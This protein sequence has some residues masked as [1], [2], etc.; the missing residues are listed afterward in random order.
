MSLDDG[1][2]WHELRSNLPHAPVHWLEIQP[3]FNDLVV[4][5]YG[6]GFWIADDITPLQQLA[7]ADL[8]ADVTLVAPRP[9]YRFRFKEAPFQQPN[10]P[11]EG[12][13]PTYGASLHYW[14][15]ATSDEEN[16]DE[17]EGEQ[18]P[19]DPSTTDVDDT[20]S[21]DGTEPAPDKIEI[22]DTDG[23]LVRTLDEIPTGPGLH[24]VHWNL[25]SEATDP[26]ALRTQ[27]DENP[28]IQVPLDPGYRRLSDGG[29][30]R[31][32]VPPGIYTVRLTAGEST[33]EQLLEVRK[34]PNTTGSE[35]DIA[36]NTKLVRHLFDGA[37]HAV[38]TINEIEWLRKQ[39]DDLES[40][41]T[42][43]DAEGK[44][45]PSEAVANMLER[46]TTL[47][48]A[49]TRPRRPVLRPAPD[50][51]GS[52]LAPLEATAL[53]Q[54]HLPGRQHARHG[55]PAHGSTAGRRPRAAHRVG[56]PP[57]NHEQPASRRRHLQSIPARCQPRRSARDRALGRPWQQRIRRRMII[58]HPR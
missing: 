23:T 20:E 3:H 19:T 2:H 57:R 47:D 55:L 24:R 32:L 22:F 4:A 42:P 56:N 18:E 41:L 27:P 30:V 15:A 6:R 58:K 53:R 7:A 26:I 39:I 29:R 52:R 43:R 5:T 36:A 14:I 8:E 16:D 17:N 34:D 31:Y 1:D 21:A 11:A 28:H 33:V 40:R 9:A 37:Q 49:P 13:N 25:T 45:E 10:D 54:D 51:R 48:D 46:A 38:E 44:A 12:T 50:R 35:A